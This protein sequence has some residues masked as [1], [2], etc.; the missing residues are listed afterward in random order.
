MLLFKLLSLLSGLI[1]AQDKLQKFSPMD[2]K[3]SYIDGYWHGIL[4]TFQ[5]VTWDQYLFYINGKRL[6]LL[7]VRLPVASLYL[8]VLQKVKYGHIKSMGLNTVSCYVFWGIIEPKRGDIPFEGFRDLQPFFDAAEQAGIYLIARPG[9]YINAETTGGGF[10]GWGTYTPGLWRSSN[11]TYVDAYTG[12]INSVGKIIAANH[13][14][15]DVI[16]VYGSAGEIHETAIKPKDLSALPVILSGG[17]RIVYTGLSNGALAFQFTTTGQTIMQLG[18]TLLHIM[19][20]YLLR[21]AS[22]GGDT[23]ALIGDLNATTLFEAVVPSTVTKLT[24]N[25]AALD[26]TKTFYGNLVAERTA[27][28]PDAPLPDLSSLIWKTADSLP[29]ININYSDAAW[30]VANH[31][32]TINPI[33]LNP[34]T[35]VVLYAG[36]YSYHT[37]NLVWCSHFILTGSETGFTARI[38]GENAFA[39]SLWLDDT[40]IGS[41]AGV[42]GQGEHTMTNKFPNGLKQGSSH[43]LTIL[44]D[45]LGY[46]ES[47]ASSNVFK[48]PRGLL[49]YSFEGGNGTKVDPWKVTG[50]LGGENLDKTRGPLNEGGLYAERQ[51]WHLPGFDDT[52]WPASKPT[53]GITHAGVVFYR[54][55]NISL[56]S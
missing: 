48:Y 53:D 47:E 56:S 9:P 29:E 14:R 54:Y 11:Q 33:N 39:Y 13:R 2:F 40:F 34:S 32:S 4:P 21:S 51:G 12:Y 42:A 52:A 3:I 49:S 41:W 27:N 36:N 35:S 55:G 10:P 8:D 30:T 7:V 28:L 23:L 16:L 15:K 1:E 5:Q 17:G 45:Y 38:W 6:M 26:T 24:F 46:E 20:G 22:I 44:Q 31:I 37:G 25:G 18:N 43:I 50:N 19:G